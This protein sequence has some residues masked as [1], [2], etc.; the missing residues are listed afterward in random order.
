MKIRFN[1]LSLL[2]LFSLSSSFIFIRLALAPALII[3]FWRITFALPPLITAMAWRK[4]KINFKESLAAGFFLALHWITWVIAIQTTTISSASLLICTGVLWSAILSKPLLRERVPKKQWFA[5]SVAL[6]GVALILFS[7]QSGNHTLFGDSMAL[8]GSLAWTIYTFIGRRARQKASFASYTTSLYFFAMI[9]TLIIIIFVDQPL[10]DYAAKTWLAF[11]ALAIF[12]T[13]LGHGTINYV[14][15]QI[16]PVSVN[17]WLLLEPVIATLAAWPL[18]AEKPSAQIIFGGIIT[19]G[20]VVLG[21]V[22]QQ[23][24]KRWLK[25]L[26]CSNNNNQAV[27]TD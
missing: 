3:V 2:A 20:A 18:F 21:I 23:K 13:L 11:I 24:I 15:R 14:L 10:I 17:L 22:P 9:F 16:D 25:K 6:C 27:K 12:P 8:I 26:L 4:E 19:I 5:L 7:K 1:L